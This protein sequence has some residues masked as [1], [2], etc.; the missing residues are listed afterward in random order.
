MRLK[1]YFPLFILCF[2][3]L[4]LV[5]QSIP[6]DISQIKVAELSESQIAEISAQFEARGVSEEQGIQLLQERGM[7]LAEAEL[8]KKRMNEVNLNGKGSNMPSTPV[9][10]DINFTRDTV[11]LPAPDHT[12]KKSLVYGSDFF[13]NPNLSF[14]PD[15]R[16]ATPQNYVLGPDDELNVLLTGQNESSVKSKISPDGNLKIPYVGLVYLNGLTIE[17]A[18][19]QIKSRMQNIYP[20]LASGQ[21]KLNVTLGSVRSIRVTIIGEVVQPG[22]Y[23]LSSLSSLFNALYLSG[24]PTEKGSL[25]NIEVVR[26]NKVIE[27]VD[28]YSFLQKGYLDANVRLEDQDVIR[29]PVY[30]K[31]VAVGGEVKRPGLYELKDHETLAN[32]LEY[33]GG[34]S[35]KAYRGM[36]KLTQIDNKER[37]V[38]DVAE[39]S[40]DRYVLKNADSVYFGAILD[41][42]SNRVVI[43]GAVYRPG[44]FE[45]T[46]GL[47]LKSLIEKAD[48]IRDDASLTNG[49]IKRTLPDL[50]KEL[51]SFNLQQVLAGNA[52]DIFLMREDSIMI[53]SKQDLKDKTSIS[54]AGHVRHPGMFLYRD[55]M[56][57]T[58]VITM[59]QGFSNDAASHRVEVSRIIKNTSDEVSNQIMEVITLNLDSNQLSA[60]GGFLL[61]PLDNIYVPRL[62]NYQS[63]GSIKIRGEVLFPGDYVQQRR[64]ETGPE[65]ISRAGGITPVGSLVNAQVFRK[66]IRVNMDFA[67]L[68]GKQNK[69]ALILMPGDSIYIPQDLP[70]VEVAGSV[71]NPQLINY[72]SRSF[73]HYV[74]AAGGTTE[75]ARL[76]GAY[77]QY[78][79]G[80]NKPVKKFLFFKK[81]PSVLP[82][83]KIIVPKKGPAKIRLGFGE[84][85]AITSSLA[86]VVTM[87]ALFVK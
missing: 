30:Q 64:D 43:E 77:V 5:A 69:S 13:S 68:K 31:R 15:I 62:V 55:G 86:A 87:I 71:N 66:G 65:Y 38:K 59:A 51:I 81:Y 74:D 72:S 57:I 76:K 83:S 28:F 3:S 11:Y 39:D 1:L 48:G 84:M 53:A 42:Y 58:D 70:F 26:G 54:I 44:V 10:E 67:D 27:S 4:R 41:R 40:F 36:A 8:L 25:R 78:A 80:L 7:P 34:F 56:K 49:Y 2:L 35:D 85:S 52:P 79:N 16:I 18:T 6:Q 50:D 33:V 61:Q 14:Q 47:S 17:Q 23:T 60:N 75:N 12:P 82:G 63:L 37:S 73:M 21:T 9:K 45:L 24:G 19:A 46:S 32:L 22:T 20:A 29:I